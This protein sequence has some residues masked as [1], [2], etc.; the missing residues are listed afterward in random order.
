LL[1]CARLD[2]V[3]QVSFEIM[4]AGHSVFLAAFF[5]EAHPQTPVLP[6]DVR[7]GH[8]KRRTDAREGKTQKADQRPIAQAND[9]CGVDAV[10][11]LTRFDR[12]QYRRLANPDHIFGAAHGGQP[13][14]DGRRR[15][16]ASDILYPGGNVNGFYIK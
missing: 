6:I 3:L 4:V 5:V 14:F 13:L 11:E 7:H 16:P 2:V 1:R 9:G 12:P 8:A 10:Q 15:K